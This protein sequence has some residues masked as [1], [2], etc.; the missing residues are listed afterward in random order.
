MA[1]P[2]EQTW[3]GTEDDE[4]V[5]DDEAERSAMA[6]LGAGLSLDDV[7]LPEDAPPSAEALCRERGAA[8]LC[9]FL[10]LQ[11]ALAARPGF[12][13]TASAPRSISLLRVPSLE[14]LDDVGYA[15]SCV[16]EEHDRQAERGEIA[17]PECELGDP[18]LVAV[19][20][21]QQH[22]RR[23]GPRRGAYV[24]RVRGAAP[25]MA[26]AEFLS[27]LSQGRPVHV[28]AADPA[29][30]HP[31]VRLGVQ[32]GL[33]IGLPDAALLL[34]LALLLR[35]EA[36]GG[37]AP[38]IP[39]VVPPGLAGRAAEVLPL[40]LLLAD[41]PGA[42][43]QQMLDH[44][45]R[46][47][48]PRH[49]AWTE[50]ADPAGDGGAAR[51]VAKRDLRREVR[52]DDLPG[53]GA[54][55][56]W[57]RQVA[58]DLRAYKLGTLP[59]TELCR[60]AVLAGPPGTGKSTIARAIAAE[61]EVPLFTGSLAEWQG[62]RD[63]HLGDLLRSMRDCFAAARRQAP[64]VLLIDEVDSF[65]N[66]AA[67]RHRHRDYVLQV[68]NGLLELLDGAVPRDGVVVVGTCN[69]PSD[70]DPALLR[71]GRLEE[72][73]PVPLPDAEALV[74]ILRVHL[75]LGRGGGDGSV[76]HGMPVSEDDLL[77]L[78]H[79]ALEREA[80]GAVVERWCRDARRR[81]AT[82]GRGVTAADLRTVLGPGRPPVTPALRHRTALHEAGH[83]LAYEAAAP[84]CVL[85][86]RLTLRGP[87]AGA[88]ELHPDR[89]PAVP[90]LHTPRSLWLTLRAQ[91]AGR[92][93]EEELLGVASSG[94]G[95]SPQSDL[96][97]ATRMA[98]TLLG[99][100][101][102][103]C[104]PE[105]LCWHG[106]PEHLSDPGARALLPP[107]LRESVQELLANAYLGARDLVRANTALV[108]AVADAL[109]ATGRLDGQDIATLL[110][111]HGISD[112]AA[113]PYEPEGAQAGEARR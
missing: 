58:A 96:A 70:L 41:R 10:M 35:G 62:S 109:L 102:V 68:V 90:P 56:P 9:A 63:G 64:C 45:D 25:R 34:D 30:V 80:T 31:T 95:G 49:A 46:M 85:E 3:S 19:R 6:E 77:D 39:P 87:L 100:H 105:A 103:G 93:A 11:R 5:F 67:V 26:E 107:D 55:G 113:D 66:R 1:E 18:R 72:V 50:E 47:L 42:S 112:P 88:T 8:S 75:G 98:L 76:D 36:E 60:G 52:L 86:A 16:T 51:S 106:P 82:Q 28:L 20:V 43:A 101:G 104:E 2:R 23:I 21:R 57:A 40:H 53:M 89:N 78:G 32:Q 12:L 91:L 81:A 27:A 13:A 110:G 59:W 65:P 33:R 73:I 48:D 14:W 44:F 69:D 97:I 7:A 54:A 79:A 99:A 61:A 111:A 15:W 94:A 83:V 22:G 38:A 29:M 84:G 17:A 108:N 4:A 37:G 74:E 24:I 92:A 71:P